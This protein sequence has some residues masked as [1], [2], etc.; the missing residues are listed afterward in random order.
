VLDRAGQWP[1]VDRPNE[2][3]TA[4]TAFLA[5]YTGASALA[6]R[7]ALTAAGAGGEGTA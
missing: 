2:V 3:A 7:P 5:R 1:F 6:A 4:V